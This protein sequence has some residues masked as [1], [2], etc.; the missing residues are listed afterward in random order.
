MKNPKKKS[1]LEKKHQPVIEVPKSIGKGETTRI[2]VAVGEVV[3]PM[4]R[5]HFIDYVELFAGNEPAGR[6]D[7][8][9]DFSVPRATFYLKLDRPVTLVARAYCNLHGLWEGRVDVA[10]A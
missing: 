2:E 8:R 4:S 7:F 9:A 1:L 5:A 6:V 10:P 3:H